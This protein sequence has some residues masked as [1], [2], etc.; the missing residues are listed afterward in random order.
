MSDAQNQAAAQYSSIVSM[1]GALEVDYDRLEELSNLS[2]TVRFVAGWNMPGY[3]PDSEP[4]SFD[5]FDSAKRYIIFVIKNDEETESESS[6][7][8]LS[9]LAEE[10]N[11]ESGPFSHVLNNRCYWIMQD[12]TMLDDEPGLRDEFD[13]LT[14]QANGCTSEDE[15]REALNSD[16]LS[17]EFRSAWSTDRDHL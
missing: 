8:L 7:E 6:A 16:P 11:L 3:M 17:V 10:V 5:D 12:G 9:A 15:A 14:E 13:E 4:A 1:L 2:K